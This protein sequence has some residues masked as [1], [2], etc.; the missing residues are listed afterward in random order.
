MGNVI[1]QLLPVDI[2]AQHFVLIFADIEVRCFELK[3]GPAAGRSEVLAADEPG[4]V[5]EAQAVLDQ[6]SQMLQR[7]CRSPIKQHQPMPHR[8]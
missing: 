1:L 6:R 5:Q 4:L 2:E 8:R 3:L 7:L